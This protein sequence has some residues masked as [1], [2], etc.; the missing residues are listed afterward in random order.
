[1]TLVACVLAAVAAGLLVYS[2]WRTPDE[3]FLAFMGLIVGVCAILVAV[4]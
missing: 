2:W 3:L 4:T 1:M